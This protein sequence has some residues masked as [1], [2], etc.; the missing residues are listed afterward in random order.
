MIVS[1]QF[2][3]RLPDIMTNTLRKYVLALSVAQHCDDLV[4]VQ[5][6]LVFPLEFICIHQ[7]TDICFYLLVLCV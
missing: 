2:F 5:L 7:S 1:Y 4:Y 6:V 3:H